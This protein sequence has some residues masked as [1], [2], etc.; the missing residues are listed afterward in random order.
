MKHKPRKK[1]KYMS[2]GL[3]LSYG[4]YSFTQGEV[5]AAPT[6]PTEM[7][8]EALVSGAARSLNVSALATTRGV[9]ATDEKAQEI[10]NILNRSASPKYFENIKTV[11]APAEGYHG[12]WY[13][14]K[15]EDGELVYFRSDQMLSFDT[16]K[17][18]LKD[19]EFKSI[20]EVTGEP[21]LSGSDKDKSQQDIVYIIDRSAQ[22][23]AEED[24]EIQLG[25]RE[26][27]NDSNTINFA[28]KEEGGN[29]IFGDLKIFVDESNHLLAEVYRLSYE[30]V[31]VTG[32]GADG[33]LRVFF[34]L[35]PDDFHKFLL[36]E[37]QVDGVAYEVN[38]T[39]LM[40]KSS[41]DNQFGETGKLQG[42]F[43]DIVI[44]GKSV[45]IEWKDGARPSWTEVSSADGKSKTYEYKIFYG[46]TPLT[47]EWTSITVEKYDD[48]NANN[49]EDED[50][51]GDYDLLFDR[52]ILE[53]KDGKLYYDDRIDER[54]DKEIGGEDG[55]ERSD[56]AERILF[57]VDSML[58]NVQTTNAA[59]E[60]T[61]S[62][63]IVKEQ[64]TR[65]GSVT[66]SYKALNEDGTAMDDTV[67]LAPDYAEVTNVDVGTEYNAS[68]K[69]ADGSPERPESIKS[70]G[71]NYHLVRTEKKENGNP[72]EARPDGKV[73][74]GT[75]TITYFYAPEQV[76]SGE[77]LEKGKVVI[78]Y[79]DLDGNTLKSERVDCDDV[80]VSRTP[81]TRRFYKYN[82]KSVYIDDTAILGQKQLTNAM[83]DATEEV[84]DER[85]DSI[86]SGGAKYHFIKLKDGS[87]AETGTVTSGVTTVTYVYSSETEETTTATQSA[88]VIV[89]YKEIGTDTELKSAYID[90]PD[91]VISTITTKRV[92]Y[93]GID[94]QPVEVSS[95]PV[96]KDVVVSYDTTE[97]DERPTEIK[98]QGKT[99]VL[100]EDKT[101]GATAGRLKEDVEVT[102]YYKE[103]IPT[104]PTAV[105]PPVLV[106]PSTPPEVADSSKNRV[107]V[108]DESERPK[109]DTYKAPKTGVSDAIPGYGL[110][111]MVS[112]LLTIV[113]SKNKRNHKNNKKKS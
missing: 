84:N 49:E 46:D 106:D 64:E 10:L 75:T 44:N 56:Y 97:T 34:R 29:Q 1:Y 88:K 95:V 61:F 19:G 78:R 30:D 93:I 57:G 108:S 18:K 105:D 5:L 9:A 99:Y 15:Q 60:Y 74:E 16:V 62:E 51:I 31:Y 94:G 87:A 85:P 48:T 109:T 66:V 90:T 50:W 89:R 23:N 72:A 76:E 43:S 41:N 42:I 82:G 68:G 96:Q 100:V 86:M 55:A 58:V 40:Y 35:A 54:V 7:N 69:K 107:F 45:R 4:I 33:V 26:L 37:I 22:T 112:G 91:T 77:I 83:Y 67:I 71:K 21:P 92:Y 2:A 102:Y 80:I 47:P 101:D 59:E 32:D 20:S 65:K 63:L 81:T 52:A 8:A 36:S 110:L 113:V 28:G 14:Y 53:E 73:V 27:Q 79:E 103:V 98:Y 38:Q 3:L 12:Y 104:P 25:F 6:V 39:P 111:S 70:E 13:V 24:Q 17:N 11:T